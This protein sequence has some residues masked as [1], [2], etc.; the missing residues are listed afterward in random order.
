MVGV[1]VWNDLV[2][3]QLCRIRTERQF[4]SFRGHNST[5]DQK[6]LMEASIAEEAMSSSPTTQ[7]LSRKHSLLICL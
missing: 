4:G 7:E 2:D 1:S 5:T 6:S 3:L